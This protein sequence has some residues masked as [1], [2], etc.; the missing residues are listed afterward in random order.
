MALTS[1]SKRCSMNHIDLGKHSTRHRFSLIC[2][3]RLAPSPF[4][5]LSAAISEVGR[6]VNLIPL[7]AIWCSHR[8]LTLMWRVRHAVSDPF[9]TKWSAA[10]LLLETSIVQLVFVI[11]EITIEMFSPC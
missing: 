1:Q 3:N 6:Y 5:K 2:G 7:L 11:S 10:A 8:A 4:A 9:R